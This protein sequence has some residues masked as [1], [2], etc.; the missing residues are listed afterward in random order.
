[1]SNLYPPG[2]TAAQQQ[3][4]P[5]VAAPAPGAQVA[6]APPAAPAPA[7][8]APQDDAPGISTPRLLRP[9]RNLSV[10]ACLVFMALAVL[11]TAL[12]GYTMQSTVADVAQGQRL[13]QARSELARADQIAGEAFLAD[14]PA[15]ELEP[16]QTALGS[17][18]Q[19]LVESAAAHPADASH[20]VQVQEEVT[21]YRRQVEAAATTTDPA[22]ASKAYTSAGDALN[23]P[24]TTLASLADDSDSRV[25]SGLSSWMR[26]LA[27]VSGWVAVAILLLTAFVLARRTHR[28]LNIGLASAFVLLAAATLVL[29]N[30]N[31]VTIDAQ[32]TALSTSVTSA[33]AL[34]DAQASA[35][36]AKAAESRYI[37]SGSSA[38]QSAWTKADGELVAAL[39]RVRPGTL[40]TTPLAQWQTYR[41]A[42]A[43]LTPLPADARARGRAAAAQV[44]TFTNSV[45]GIA[46]A[47]SAD[48]TT[49]LRAST[50]PLLPLA[51]LA[52]LAGLAAAVAAGLGVNRRLAEYR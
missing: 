14:K 17:V 44:T 18:S 28:I 42:H 51:A 46:G 25:T 47:Q 26:T 33:R 2:V 3:A 38:Y 31:A 6:T 12:P 4:A 32:R 15:A 16:F 35:Y 23:A 11:G 5:P 43:A 48:A 45:G 50:E 13:R 34:R 27:V 41:T 21:A 29:S 36:R 7:P 39:G 9:L 24:L 19:L 8:A 20:L 30:Q 40:V 52:G 10:L 37:L 22:A 1:M 49:S